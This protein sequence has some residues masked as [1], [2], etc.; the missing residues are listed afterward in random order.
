MSGKETKVDFKVVRSECRTTKK[1]D[2]YYALEL[3][4]ANQK[5][6]E[7]R[8]WNDVLEGRMGE[9]T[10]PQDGQYWGDVKYREN[11]FNGQKQLVI[12]DYIIYNSQMITD[13]VKEQ[14]TEQPVI[15]V[16]RVIDRMFNW[17][18]WDAS[19]VTLMKGVR[20]ELE[21]EG[22]WDKIKSIPAGAS[23]HHSVRGGFLLHIDE[24]LSFSENIISEHYLGLV[25]YQIL[26]AAI[27]LH[28]IGKLYDYDEKTLQ[29]QDN[30]VSECLE[31][32]IVAILLVERHWV[33]DS[34]EAVDRGLR[35]MHALAAHHGPEMGAV[36]PKTPEAIILHHLDMI[37]AS[38]DI[39][40]NA[41]ETAKR[42]GI[43]ADYSKML[44]V[45]PFI[46]KFF[47]SNDP[48]VLPGG[49]IK[50]EV[51]P[52]NPKEETPRNENK[53]PWED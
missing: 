41:Y 15:D 8:I 3:L 42:L 12:L 50:G 7:A 36:K 35:L 24:L 33:K 29:Y 11:V 34:A 22:I 47:L 49:E 51:S 10:L 26:R 30:P 43:Q 31:H 45:R 18:Y 40:R 44:G 28:D 52:K 6:R 46:P 1:G 21:Q 37:S 20:K 5:R 32:T 53:L 4:D 39:C 38:L 23:Y 14:F 27:V 17:P 25:D 16:D 2:P 48:V 19:M 13:I 9:D